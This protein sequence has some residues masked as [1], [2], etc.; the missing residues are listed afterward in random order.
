VRRKAS[1][2]KLVKIKL[3][4]FA[5]MKK[6]DTSFEQSWQSKPRA[7][8]ITNEKSHSSIY[9]AIFRMCLHRLVKSHHRLDVAELKRSAAQAGRLVART[10]YEGALLAN[11]GTRWRSH[12][13]ARR[14]WFLHPHIPS[15][16]SIC[17][18]SSPFKRG[19]G[20]THGRNFW[21]I[22]GHRWVLAH[23]GQKSTPRSTRFRGW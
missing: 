3:R 9:L 5:L 8:A 18:P 4:V 21:I 16:P 1:K 14:Y 23:F 11:V 13:L 12:I 15:P 19:P 10:V 7:W 22:N 2:F 6:R 17:L 20:K